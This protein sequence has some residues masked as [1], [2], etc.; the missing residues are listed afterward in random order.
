MATKNTNT[1]QEFTFE[2]VEHIGVLSISSSGWTRE[3]NR[4]SFS[5]GAP[6]FDIRSFD[7]EHKKMSKG[8]RLHEKEMEALAKMLK[9]RF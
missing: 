6:R 7:P 1:N 2:I 4:V 5:G 8:L 9:D 3:L